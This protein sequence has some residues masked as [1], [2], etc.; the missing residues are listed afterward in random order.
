MSLLKDI[1]KSEGYKEDPY[2]DTKGI[3]TGGYGHQILP[4]EDI[5]FLNKLTSSEKQE[6]WTKVLVKD[7]STANFDAAWISSDWDYR[8]N[9]I[10]LEV[11]SELC[12]NLGLTRLR[13]FKKFLLYFSYGNITEAAKELIDSK[14]H[15]DF[16]KWNSGKDT[17]SIRSRRLEKKLLESI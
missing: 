16:V 8:P 7:I 1:I 14:W 17:P 9:D 15:R 12:F 2:Y 3:L 6:Y 5:S 10:Q 4:H 11:L 13:K